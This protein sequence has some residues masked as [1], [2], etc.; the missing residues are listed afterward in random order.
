[1]ANSDQSC[2]NISLAAAGLLPRQ[3]VGGTLF[4]RH[5]WPAL[6]PVNRHR[7]VRLPWLLGSISGSTTVKGR[8]NA[9]PYIQRSIANAVATFPLRTGVSSQTSKWRIY[10]NNAYSHK[11][12][13]AVLAEGVGAPAS[14][15]PRQP[16]T[17]PHPHGTSA[18]RPPGR[19][20]Q[21]HQ[22]RLEFLQVMFPLLS[23]AIKKPLVTP[24]LTKEKKGKKGDKPRNPAR[25]PTE[26]KITI[27]HNPFPEKGKKRKG[28]RGASH[29]SLHSDSKRRSRPAS[30]H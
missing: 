7:Y 10:S 29:I 24:F 20:N 21:L 11:R 23:C 22:A 25:N 30:T 18:T 13:S 6:Y 4:N 27:E 26:P 3:K 28:G 17:R 8:L 12:I 2:H 9:Q 19:K 16:P 14:R 15:Q 1:M 5:R